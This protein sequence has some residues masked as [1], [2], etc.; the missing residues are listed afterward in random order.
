MDTRREFIKK[1]TF[2]SGGA[3]LLGGL[4]AS[5]QKAFAIDP[6]AGSTYLDAEHI[7]FLMQE[8]RSFDHCYG[9]LQGVRGYNDPRAITLP[10]KNKVWA[11]TNAKG[12]TYAPFRLN[13][14]DSRSTW[15]GSL[16]HS[17][18][19]MTDARNEGK[20]D[21]WLDAKKSGHKECR[22]MPLTMGFY[23]RQDIPFYYA[24]A[25]AF[26]VCDQHFCSSLTGTTPNRLYFWTGTIREKHDENVVANVYNSNVSYD[27]EAS[28]KTFPEYL[29]EN[30]ISWKIYQNEVS[31]E[32]GFQGEEEDWLANFTDNPMEWFRQY[33]IRFSHGHMKFLPEAEK[34]LP[35]MISELEEEIKKAPA[36]S[37]ELSKLQRALE[38]RK[39]QYAYVKEAVKK[40]NTD[41]YRK[42]S[43][44]SKNLHE[45]AFTDNRNDPDYRSLT[46]VTYD[47]GGTERTMQ[48]PKSDVLHQFRTDVKDGKLPAVSWLVAPSNFSDHPGSPWYGAWYVSEVLDILTQNPEVWKKTIFILNYDENDGY[49][50][51]VPP[52]VPPN[53][54]KENSG[55]VSAGIYTKT[56]YVSRDQKWLETKAYDEDD[57]EGPIG[58]GFRVPLV[59]AS[60]WSRGG[61]VCSEVF[62]LTSPIQFME[63]FLSHKTG[64]KIQSAEV[65]SWRRAVSGNLT[66]VFRPYNGEKIEAPAP[67]E[68]IPFLEGIH[69]A[70]FKDMPSGYK[71][72][73]AE[74]V[75]QINT[76]RFASP[77][78]PQQEK[79]TRASC[80][81]PYELYSE[82]K[83]SADKKQFFIRLSAKKD[84]FGAKAIG[85]P[86]NIYTP[87]K[88]DLPRN[89]AVLAGDSLTDS[90]AL[91]DD[92]DY[93]LQVYGP[94]GFF[95]E[96]KGNTEDPAA[97]VAC[98]YQQ[99]SAGRKNLSGN[100]IIKIKN[101]SSS[102]LAFTVTDN[103][104]TTASQ[105]KTV[106][107]GAVASVVV[108]LKK[109]SGWYDVSVKADGY[110]SFE[111]RYA[112]RVETGRHGISDPVM[113]RVI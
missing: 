61:W 59:I 17:W 96:F 91:D 39:A 78:M 64:K 88:D 103:A 107:A 5:I 26:T 7:V 81:L 98:E 71:L 111:K 56:D 112:G 41:N 36:G 9:T 28:W 8:N 84:V 79:G 62:D 82:G 40:Y 100:I 67:V 104:Y 83:L 48:I 74:E 15:L 38:Q 58:L 109:S 1:A 65:T 16:P 76:D 6:K 42:L 45:K 37:S 34:K 80:A 66:S 69:K 31:I 50:D 86:F 14:R 11:Q 51:H 13:I 12:E 72:L 3:G 47:D 70:Q 25:D 10:N 93:H 60:P 33:N 75:A 113:G 77:Y 68:R 30:G 43:Q 92:G 19:N 106:S 29:E 44:R 27:S 99:G 53:P 21:K 24:L 89:Y 110:N 102:Q 55:K 94:N 23:D 52:F 22:D 97:E 32:T 101:N 85:A 73:T 105:T 87:S 2:L 108:D 95:R 49:F 54:Y 4:P 35:G 90:W 63:H 18:D 46:S 57:R 20:H